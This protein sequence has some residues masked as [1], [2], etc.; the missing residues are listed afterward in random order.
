MPFAQPLR[1]LGREGARPCTHARLP[2]SHTAQGAFRSSDSTHVRTSY[3]VALTPFARPCY[4][5]PCW[6]SET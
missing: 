3:G 4:P 6:S 1:T 5:P 2:K